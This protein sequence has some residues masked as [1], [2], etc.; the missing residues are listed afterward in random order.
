VLK[1]KEIK[2]LDND[3]LFAKF[4]N[5]QKEFSVLYP[6]AVINFNFDKNFYKK[7]DPSHIKKIKNFIDKTEDF[8]IVIQELRSRNYT[9]SDITDLEL[10]K[11]DNGILF[12]SFIGKL[13]VD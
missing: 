8:L 12:K 10:S 5:L 6:E 11:F 9:I 4:I 2:S 13:D 1:K 7:D 3:L